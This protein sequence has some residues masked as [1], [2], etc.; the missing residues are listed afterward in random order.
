MIMSDDFSDIS[1]GEVVSTTQLIEELY[2]D[3]IDADLIVASQQ[4]DI[5]LA[6]DSVLDTAVKELYG[7]DKDADLTFASQQFDIATDS[8][9][10]SAAVTMSKTPASERPFTSPIAQKELDELNCSRFTKKTVDKSIW[11]V[12]V[13]GEWQ[14]H[15][16][17]NRFDSPVCC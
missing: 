16:N 5:G 12:T 8:V 15:R 10:D 6:T 13:I 17:R 14:G 1:D 9:P 2:G 4:F 7:E 3:N 11:A